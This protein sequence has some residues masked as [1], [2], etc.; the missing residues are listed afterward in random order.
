MRVSSLTAPSLVKWCPIRDESRL[1]VSATPQ[2]ETQSPSLS[3]NRLD[4]RTPQPKIDVVQTFESSSPY[5]AVDWAVHQ[6]KPNGIIAAGHVDGSIDVI[7]EKEVH[8]LSGTSSNQAPIS[9]LAFNPTQNNVLLSVC[10]KE[11]SVWDLKVAEQGKTCGTGTLSRS[12]TGTVTGIAWH[13]APNLSSFFG[14]CDAN[15]QVMVW[16]L[17]GSRSTHSFTDTTFRSALSDIK[18][19]PH[20]KTL[21]ATAS[22]DAR[23]AVVYMWDLRN[24][25]EPMRKMHGHTAGINCLEWPAADERILLSAGNDGNIIVWN[26][27]TGEQINTISEGVSAVISLAWS[28][29]ISGA[30]LGSSSANTNIYSLADPSFGSKTRLPNVAYHQRACGLD[31]SF[32]GR[33]FQFHGDKVKSSEYKDEIAE[34]NDFLNFVAALEQKKIGEFVGEKITST[35]DE[36]E[37]KLWEVTQ[38]AMSPEDFNQNLLKKFNIVA[39]TSAE[40]LLPAAKPSAEKENATESSAAL[41]GDAAEVEADFGTSAAEEVF[42][43]VFAPFRVL[44]KKSVDESGNIIASAL[45]SGNIQVAIDCAFNA[46]KYAEALIIASCGG[47]EMFKAAKNRY[48][49]HMNSPLTRLVSHIS[50]EKLDTFVRYAKVKDWKEIFAVLCNYA[51]DNFDSL[52]CDLGRR[53]M[54]EK[55]DF[56]SALYCFVAAKQY[57]MVQQC[58][59]NIYAS[60]QRDTASAEVILLVMEKMCAMAGAK[61]G[62]VISDVARSF[63]QHVIQSG[64]KDDAIRFVNAVP[65]NS[66]LLELKNALT[67]ADKPHVQTR[68]QICPQR[69]TQVPQP[70]PQP[71]AFYNPGAASAM[72]PPTKAPPPPS[73]NV[74]RPEPVNTIP[75]S[76]PRPAAP[77]FVPSDLPPQKRTPP[78][79]T[80]STRPA[81]PTP[82]APVQ[83]PPT[84][85]SAPPGPAMYVPAPSAPS[86]FTPPMAPPGAYKS[87]AVQPPPPAAPAVVKPPPPTPTIVTAPPVNMPTM[88]PPPM[89]GHN[90]PPAVAPP[91]MAQA[92]INQPPRM[93]TVAAPPP[94]PGYAPQFATPG[95]PPM[96]AAPA[97]APEPAPVQKR[98]DASIDEV[99]SETRG[100]ADSLAALVGLIE[101]RPELSSAAKKALQDAKL[102]LPYVYAAFRDGT[103][104]PEML[105][106]LTAFIQKLNASDIE[107]AAQIRKKSTMHMSKCRDVVLLMSYIQNAMR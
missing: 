2:T 46:E 65:N 56:E 32:D 31:V 87:P 99:P 98:P 51:H 61:A 95:M 89:A 12:V 80:A 18:F 63:L 47:P 49:R 58:L 66:Q 79:P 101:R 37:K 71:G 90:H 69:P 84:I 78:P 15:G 48:I 28:P 27:E 24:T 36:T 8:T 1:F 106:N 10:E 96:N 67:G 77:N 94:T 68:P 9:C 54:N 83:P 74:Y 60:D 72:V 41:F 50:E 20:N 21:L 97:P 34:S 4:F 82:Q 42:G 5:T 45:I 85:V 76:Q 103:V 44:P 88:A 29:F 91:P 55:N 86:T 39:A 11:I 93:P 102:K 19:A 81:Y 59:F 38:L 26:T 13:N 52:C 92:Q 16:D 40:Q 107:S 6:S 25:A 23:N 7:F 17:R 64:H 70:Q 3:V 33:I 14:F 100:L 105:Q 75:V 35:E 53:L 62:L 57:D 104:E 22:S 73:H 30:L 43:E